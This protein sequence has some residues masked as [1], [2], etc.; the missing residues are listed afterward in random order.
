MKILFISDN[1]YPDGD[2]GAVRECVIAKMLSSNGHKIYRVGRFCKEIS[3][4]EEVRCFSIPDKGKTNK[5]N[6]LNLLFFNM[7]IKKIIEQSDLKNQYDAFFITGLKARLVKWIKNYAI[8]RNIKLIYNSV[9]YYSHEQFKYGRFARQFIT[10]RKIALKIIDSNFRVVCISSFLKELF[11]KREG[12]K[13]VRVPFILDVFEIKIKNTERQNGRIEI[14]YIGR[15][16]RG[17]DYIKNFIEALEMLTNEE[18]EKIHL[19]IVGI[20]K[21]ELIKNFGVSKDTL[22]YLKN[23]IDIKGLLS[24]DDAMIILSKS[25]FTVL[26]RSETEVYAKAGFPTK[27]TESLANGIPVITNKTSDLGMYIKD[28]YNSFIIDEKNSITSCYRKAIQ[29]SSEE[30]DEMKKNARYTAENK[31][32]MHCFEKELNDIFID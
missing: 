7:R 8:K 17:K 24:R 1:R 2:A 9:E 16:G 10:N 30:L 21:E 27:V 19:T 13:T 32:D 14:S 29:L 4:I 20:N 11:E 6:L 28:K 5:G 26:Y 12:I 31:L 15:P 25:D 3:K 23:S 22:K 18:L